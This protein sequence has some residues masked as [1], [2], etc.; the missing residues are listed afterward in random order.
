MVI[1]IE[2]ALTVSEK[3][4]LKIILDD[5][6]VPYNFSPNARLF[7]DDHVFVLYI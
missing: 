1:N 3:K 5:E 4:S 2:K 6:L 7:S